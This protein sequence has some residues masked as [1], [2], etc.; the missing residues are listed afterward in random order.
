MSVEDIDIP[1]EGLSATEQ[2]NT[3]TAEEQVAEV[4]PG[5]FDKL[6]GETSGQ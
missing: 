6:L 3:D 4:A 2:E 1:E 5:K